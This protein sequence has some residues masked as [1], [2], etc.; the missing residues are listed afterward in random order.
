MSIKTHLILSYCVEVSINLNLILL[1]CSSDFI[2][3]F[4]VLYTKLNST[5]MAPT[6][7]DSIVTILP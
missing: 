6:I 4:F 1:Y 7:V 3:L 5:A 2:V